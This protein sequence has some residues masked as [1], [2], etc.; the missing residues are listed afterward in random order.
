MAQDLTQVPAGDVGVRGYRNASVLKVSRNYNPDGLEDRERLYKQCCCLQ[1]K[2]LCVIVWMVQ[3]RSTAGHVS[4]CKP[5]KAKHQRI[6]ARSSST[7]YRDL[8]FDR[9]PRDSNHPN[10]RRIQASLVVSDV[11][12]DCKTSGS[13]EEN[14]YHRSAY[15]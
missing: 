8:L 14:K 11:I 2:N 10:P 12:L 13:A 4:A 7:Q 6:Q 3:E 9:H 5:V 1:L 15:N